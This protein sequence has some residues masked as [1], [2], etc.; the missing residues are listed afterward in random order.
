MDR[1][2]SALLTDLYQL[3]MV[4]AY[5]ET[6]QT[7]TAVFEFF[8]RK[9]PPQRNF[10]V[11]A[12]LEQA[13]EFLQDL[14]FSDDELS[15]LIR[16]GRFSAR[17]IDY[18]S[19]FRFSG[20]VHAMPEG[21]V[22]FANEPILRVT[23]PLPEAQLVETRL[24]NVLHFQSLIAS[25]AA[26]MALLAPDKLLVDFGLRRAHGA[27]AGLLAARASYIGGIAG[28]ATVLAEKCF[29]IPACGTMAHSFIQSFDDE[30]AAFESFARARPKDLVLLIDTYDTEMAARKVV[31]LAPRLRTL[32][33]SVRGVR[34]D[35]GDLVALS[36][37]VRRILDEGGLKDVTIFVSGGIEEETLSSF[38]R[39]AAPIDGIGIGTS[40][41]TSSDAPA[42]DC[43]YKL[44]EYAGVARRKRSAG[45]A[46]WPGRK[47][48]WRRYDAE[49]LMASDVLSTEDDS[50][51][52][53]A[54][55]GP[56]LQEGRPV[57]HQPSLQDIR[58]H[59]RTQVERLPRG[60]ERLQTGSI[61]PVHV[62]AR[63]Q[64]LA[65]AVDLRMT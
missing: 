41:A 43:A 33:I 11:A 22:F 65:A 46:T 7:E 32:G 8:V 45:K 64:Q 18:L 23:A 48:V 30:T 12:G 17:L 58:A 51:E 56:V 63:L 9:L 26:R 25:K 47:Q 21:A 6:G 40:L 31:A 61:Y 44:Q 50:Q 38:I 4:Q 49:G 59:A 13:L 37:R 34:I 55:I 62:A 52:G 42:L 28:T 39:E 24:I 36:R 15:W 27:E 35:S 54:L 14:R 1:S 2:P 19:D 20:D 10:L 60:F 57:A 3:N 29:G 5:L 53:E 16:G